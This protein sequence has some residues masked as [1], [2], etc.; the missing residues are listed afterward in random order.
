MKSSIKSLLIL[1]VILGFILSCAQA[2]QQI[3]EKTLVPTEKAEESTVLLVSTDSKS[4][5]LG[6]GFF[7][8]KDKIATN[9]HVVAQSGNVFAKLSDKEKILS[10]EGVVAYDVKNNLVILKLAGKGNPLPIGDSD[11]IQSG[12]TVSVVGYLDS[13]D[14][15]TTGTIDSIY[16]SDRWFQIEVTISEESSGGP[17]LNSKGQVIG[18]AVGYGDDSD[19]YAIPSN[20]LKAL[21]TRSIPMESLAAWQ[22][23]KSIRAEAHQSRG[24]RKYAAKKYKKAIVDFD[25]AISLNPEHVRAYYMRGNTKYELENYAAAIDDYTHAIKLNP[26]H[27]RAFNN[28]GNTKYKLENHTA[29]IDD[30]THAIKLNPDDANTFNNRGIVKCKL[31]DIESKRGDAENAKRLYHEGIVDVGKSIQL[32]Y[33]ADADASIVPIESKKGITSTV[34]VMNWSGGLYTGSGFF[35]DTDKI[36][37]NIHNIDNPGPVYAKLINNEKIW[38]VEEVTAFDVKNDLVVLKLSGEGTPLPLG[39]SNAVQIGDSVVTV[40][41]PSNKYKVT[42]G[43]VHNIRNRDKWIVTTANIWGGNSGGPLLN[44]KGEV[45]GINTHGTES[46]NYCISVPSNILKAL[47]DQ[48]V[49]PEPL[50]QWQKRDQI[51]AYAYY[52]IGQS[53]CIAGNYNKALINFEKAILHYPIHFDIYDWRGRTKHNLGK[54]KESQG[55]VVE[56]QKLYKA[57][58]EDYTETIKIDPEDANTFYNRGNV[59]DDLAQSKAEQDNVAE[60]QQLYQA[61]IDDYTHAIKLEPKDPNSYFNRR[62]T[63]DNLAQSKAEQNNIDE[64]QDLYEAA[65]NDFTQAIKINPKYTNA[66]NNRGWTKYNFGISKADQEDIAEAQQLYKEAIDDYTEAINITL[67]HVQ[68]YKNRGIAKYILAESKAEQGDIAEAQKLYKAA[69]EDY[70]HAIKLNPKDAD[71]YYNRGV[72]KHDLGESKTGPWSTVEAQYMYKAALEDYNRAIQLQPKF[73]HAYKYRGIIKKALGQSDEAEKD[74]AKAK[75]LESEK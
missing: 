22:K 11:A 38:K 64:A 62:Y 10:I 48:S 74:F 32:R 26:E 59:R 57:A 6:S 39:D 34:S 53:N 20:A 24:E 58:I 35:M 29:A 30:Y 51:R 65:I 61:A 19:N 4:N 42:K 1:L 14:K 15:T 5:K 50:A 13:K 71:T 54:S 66:Y 55:D 40:G 69:I 75:E 8:D 12:D 41:Y 47:L 46:G 16:K 28:R 33:M 45:I 52:D 9:I 7:V 43:K 68:A 23:R 25:K 49:S 63:R 18:I 3:A 56:A 27:A 2:P 17:V 70:T 44:S 60:A 72:A 37:T 73:I 36:A 31:G 21:L 67:N